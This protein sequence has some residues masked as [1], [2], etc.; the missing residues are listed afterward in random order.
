MPLF[1]TWALVAGWNTGGLIGG[2][3]AAYYLM[4]VL[5]AWLF[6]MAVYYTVKQ[7]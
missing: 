4:F 2:I 3:S 5:V 6:A 1:V 7:M